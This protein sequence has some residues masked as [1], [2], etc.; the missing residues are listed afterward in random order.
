DAEDAV[1]GFEMAPGVPGERRHPVTELDAVLLE[2]LRDLE[3]ACAHFRI[4]GRMH[5][6]LDR[7]REDAALGVV[8]GRVVDDPMAQQRPVLHQSAH[9][10][11]SKVCSAGASLAWGRGSTGTCGN[12]QEYLHGAPVKM[13]I[14]AIPGPA[15]LHSA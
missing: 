5:R 9:G 12:G 10:F 7:P 4:G 2:P 14:A 1:P 6:A 15:A 13:G 8:D 11:P 3:R